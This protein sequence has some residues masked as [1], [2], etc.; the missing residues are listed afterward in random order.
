[1]IARL[2]ARRP[3]DRFPDAEALLVELGAIRHFLE[4]GTL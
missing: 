2:T 4:D 3:D 1:M